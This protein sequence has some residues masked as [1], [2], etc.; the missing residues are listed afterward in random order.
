MT[1]NKCA[2]NKCIFCLPELLTHDKL[3]SNLGESQL[4]QIL[5]FLK[6]LN[7]MPPMWG[8][9]KKEVYLY[10][11]FHLILFAICPSTLTFVYTPALLNSFSITI[12]IMP[13]MPITS[14]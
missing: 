8:V 11:L 1:I 3:R 6:L 7:K 4:T 13:N 12:T 9:E 2:I 10:V 14:A 5:K